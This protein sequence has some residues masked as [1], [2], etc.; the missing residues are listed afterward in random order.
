D[1]SA[2]SC[3]APAKRCVLATVSDWCGAVDDT[4]HVSRIQPAGDLRAALFAALARGE[5]AGRRLHGRLGVV[6]VDHSRAVSGIAL[7]GM[8]SAIDHYGS[9]GDE[10]GS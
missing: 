5:S 8:A 10:R 2:R 9:L 3:S 1:R 7:G 4:A 6:G